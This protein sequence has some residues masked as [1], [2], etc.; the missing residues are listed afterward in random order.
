MPHLLLGPSSWYQLAFEPR[1]FL[2]PKQSPL[3]E[4][5]PLQE[6][7]QQ[8]GLGATPT[9]TALGP[10]LSPQWYRAPVWSILHWRSMDRPTPVSTRTQQLVQT[11]L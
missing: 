9:Y 8:D 3:G 1:S 10:L 5:K 4:K 7:R 11:K 6:K 2:Y